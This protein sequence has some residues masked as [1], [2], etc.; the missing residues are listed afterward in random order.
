MKHNFNRSITIG[1]RIVSDDLPA[2]IIAEAGVNHN[3]DFAI[4]KELIDIAA[5]AGAD[6]V[7]FQ[8]FKADSLILVGVKK[9][10]YQS[11]TTSPE[12]SQYQMLK[13]LEVS[14]QQNFELS[15]YCK[16][17]SIIFLT[18]PFDDASLDEL[19][20]LDLTAYK[21]ASTDTTN[22]PFLGRIAKTGK[23]VILSTGMSY[24]TEVELAVDTIAA[25]NKDL[26]LLQ[27]TAN[28]PTA[29]SE[30]NLSVIETFRNTFDCI[31][32]Y[33]DHTTGVGAAPFA[34]SMGAK[35]IEKHF[36]LDKS[37]DGP[38]HRASLSPMELSEFVN[39]IRRVEAYMGSGYKCPTLA[40]LGTRASLQKCLVARREICI[41]EIFSSD[42]LTAKRTGGTGISPIYSQ[43]ILGKA[44]TRSYLPDEIIER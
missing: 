36:T 34:I 42:N 38:D 27:C 19:E 39:T 9:A 25:S 5:E 6:A 26:I 40:E 35:V 20:A 32:G 43:A 28:Y 37:M 3:G 23:P 29:D 4:A 15:E 7:K 13:R 24:M 2:M 14:K 8:T 1:D 17:R 16:K 31:V 10:P 30:A 18:T 11:K 22:L 41:G 12:E 21:V 44:A 33:S